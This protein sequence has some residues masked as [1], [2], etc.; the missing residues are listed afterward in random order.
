VLTVL[1]CVALIVSAVYAAI[2]MEAAW[3]TPP[4]HRSAAPHA[5]EDAPRRPEVVPLPESGTA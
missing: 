4:A 2:R 1:C 3:L 5:T